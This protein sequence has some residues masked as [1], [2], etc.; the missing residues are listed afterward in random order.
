VNSFTARRQRP[1]D[2][3]VKSILD[4]RRGQGKAPSTAGATIP[5]SGTIY[6]ARMPPAIPRGALPAG[7]ISG[8]ARFPGSESSEPA[9]RLLLA[10]IPEKSAPVG[11]QP[12][13]FQPGPADGN[14]MRN[15]RSRDCRGVG[16]HS[17]PGEVRAGLGDGPTRTLPILRIM[18]IMLTNGSEWSARNPCNLSRSPPLCHNAA[19]PIDRGGGPWRHDCGGFPFC[20]WSASAS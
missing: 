14:R 18:Y 10:G 8:K 7:A 3:L 20:P 9:R 13:G 4:R 15:P 12:R 19:I 2:Q 5:Q 1:T 17:A 11:W 6:P 16:G